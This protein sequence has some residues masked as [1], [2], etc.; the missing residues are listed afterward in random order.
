MKM[1]GTLPLVLL[2]AAP[3]AAQSAPAPL[4][5]ESFRH[6]STLILEQSFEVKLTPQEPI[7]RERIKDSRGTDRF[8]FSLV[9]RGPEGD[10]TITSWEAKLADLRHPIY[11]NVL[12]VS[13]QPPEDPKGD[14]KEALWR[15]DPVTSPRIPLGTRR[16]IKVDSFYVVL[17]MKSH[18]TTPLESPYLDS[19]VVAVE[20]RNTDPRTKEE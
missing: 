17:Q 9:P 14:P 1:A 11:D 2:L 13:P 6:G 20:F 7:Y 8:A 3:L 5:A 12:M 19:M 18:H 16:V 10:N 4:F 15:L